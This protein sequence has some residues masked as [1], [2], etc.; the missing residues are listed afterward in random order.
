MRLITQGIHKRIVR[1]QKLTRN[2]FLTLHGHNL[3]RQQQQLSKF[4]MLYQQFAFRAYCGAA[5]PRW[6]R[7]RKS[8]SV[9]S[10]LRCPHLWLQCSLSFVHGLKKTQLHLKT[11]HTESLFL[12]RRHLGNWPRGPLSKHEKRTAGRAW[13]TWTVAAAGGVSCVR[14]RWEIHFLLTFEIAPFF[15][16]YPVLSPVA[17]LALKQFPTISHKRHG[18]RNTVIEHKMYVLI[19]SKPLPETFFILRSSEQDIIINANRFSCTVF[20]MHVR[21]Y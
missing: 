1:F 5:G 18:F 14:V 12:L 21:R 19:F 4:L 17:C 8:L 13:E 20:I 10:V 6:R 11:E 16:V 9:C 3:H 7:S 15:C 2:V